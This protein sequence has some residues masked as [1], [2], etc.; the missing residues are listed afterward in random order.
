MLV[1]LPKGR[2]LFKRFNASLCFS[3]EIYQNVRLIGRVVGEGEFDEMNRR[4]GFA[5]GWMKEAKNEH[6][7]ICEWRRVVRA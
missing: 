4:L 6:R 3:V 2:A 7:L 5:C 1:Q